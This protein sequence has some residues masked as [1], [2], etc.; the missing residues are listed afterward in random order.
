VTPETLAAYRAHLEGANGSRLTPRALRELFDEIDRLTQL[1]VNKD[2]ANTEIYAANL[3]LRAEVERLKTELG[4]KVE[5]TI[6]HVDIDGTYYA[7]EYTEAGAR[8]HA[9]LRRQGEHF[10]AYRRVGNWQR[11]DAPEPGEPDLSNEPIGAIDV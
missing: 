3:D 5:W 11:A 9:A 4:D 8:H 6:G 10:P 2:Q 1:T 7:G